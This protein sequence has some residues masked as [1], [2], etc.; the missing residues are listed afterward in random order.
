MRFTFCT[1]SAR[2]LNFALKKELHWALA[3]RT[4]C[5][6]L[7][8]HREWF[9][10]QREILYKALGQH[11]HAQCQ[12]NFTSFYY[13]PKTRETFRHQHKLFPPQAALG[14]LCWGMGL[15]VLEPNT[16]L[17]WIRCAWCLRGISEGLWKGEVAN[18]KKCL[19][20]AEPRWNEVELGEKG[21]W[22]EPF[23]GFMIVGWDRVISWDAIPVLL[24][25]CQDR[26][27][28]FQFL[29]PVF[30]YPR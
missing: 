22:T 25:A 28:L 10:F 30:T 20:S 15:L 13:S 14:R 4:G 26:S 16:C 21:F 12:N 23:Q 7:N 29:L 1:I 24:Y 5:S 18:G 2:P 8:H 3:D 11:L 9:S 27:Y 19:C 17:G 6:C